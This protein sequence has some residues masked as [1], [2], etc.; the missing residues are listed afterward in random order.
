[1]NALS[2]GPAFFERIVAHELGVPARDQ[3]LRAQLPYPF[4]PM[5]SHEPEQRFDM[6]V[7]AAPTVSARDPVR[8][9]RQPASIEPYVVS[10]HPEN[11]GSILAVERQGEPLIAQPA[12][13]RAEPGTTRVE[14][15]LREGPP[16]E[17]SS[18]RETHAAAADPGMAPLRLLRARVETIKTP[19]QSSRA[20][21]TP[22]SG[23]AVTAA[24]VPRA[25]PA[26]R[27]VSMMAHAPLAPQATVSEPVIEIHIGRLEVRAQPP[28]VH[29][30]SPPRMPSPKDDRLSEY[31]GRR[32]RGARS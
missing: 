31:L 23:S 9:T 6:P 29:T 24:P 3:A 22:D 4:E 32:G 12:P 14:H 21:T 20:V 1:M 26:L 11:I 2:S 8:E 27:P 25:M 5:R 18:R 15:I 28:Q 16:A 7:T 10:S 30:A 19:T 13:V 17:T